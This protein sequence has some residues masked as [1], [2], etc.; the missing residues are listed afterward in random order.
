MFLLLFFL[1]ESIFS[2]RQESEF[3][4]Y[5]FLFLVFSALTFFVLGDVFGIDGVLA[6]STDVV[7]HFEAT[8]GSQF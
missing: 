3:V 8:G 6:A 1:L 7:E 4:L 5:K 2:L